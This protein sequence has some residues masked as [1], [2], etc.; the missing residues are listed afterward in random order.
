MQNVRVN[1]V[2][3]CCRHKGEK[4]CKCNSSSRGHSFPRVGGLSCP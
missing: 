1:A 4:E 2:M 3:V